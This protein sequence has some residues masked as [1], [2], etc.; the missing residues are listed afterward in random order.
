M[1][2]Y[3][4]SEDHIT[5]AVRRNDSDE[6]VCLYMILSTSRGGK[7]LRSKI[8]LSE[9]DVIECSV[10]YIRE[11]V[12]DGNSTVLKILMTRRR[13]WWRG[14]I[15]EIDKFR[16]HKPQEVA[17]IVSICSTYTSI[18]FISEYLR[19][20]PIQSSDYIK[21]LKLVAKELN[22]RND[23]KLVLAITKVLTLAQRITVYKELSTTLQEYCD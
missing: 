17:A 19:S 15:P 22:D 8:S 1:C 18:K 4:L 6:L 10:N 3:F 23:E 11:L 20:I 14:L 7:T 21:C 9:W 2:D 12:R 5:E 16:I 13:G